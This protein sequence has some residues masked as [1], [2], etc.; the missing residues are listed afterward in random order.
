M[1]LLL[2]IIVIVLVFGYIIMLGVIID[3]YS[4]KRR[5]YKE[6]IDDIKTKKEIV[7]RLTND[8]KETTDR[9]RR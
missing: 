7:E 2:I 6:M 3:Y 1:E 9:D 4:Y 5:K 8:E